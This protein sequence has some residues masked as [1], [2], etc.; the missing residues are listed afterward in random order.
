MNRPFYCFL[1][2][3]ILLATACGG[4]KKKSM[5]G[6]DEVNMDEFMEVYP[7]LTLPFTYGDS[8]FSEKENDSNLIAPQ[9]FHQFV[10]DS[11]TIAAFG[12]NARPRYYPVGS[13]D[14]GSGDFYLLSRGM[15][16]SQKILLITAYD[17]KKKFIAGLPVIKLSRGTDKT[18]SVTID[19]R[20]NINKNATQKLANGIEITGNDVFVLN[21]AAGKFM[22]IMTDSLGDGT[23]ELVNPIDTLP[24]KEKYSGDYGKG[25]TELIS[26][27]D[28]QREG[29]F[30]FFIHL[31]DRD[32]QCMGELKGEA[33]FNAPATAVYRQG[34]DPCVLRFVFE[35]NS[36]TL[37]EVEG[38]GSRL[39]ALQCSFNGTYPRKKEK[40]KEP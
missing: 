32:K 10:P 37:Q 6:G 7:K 13:I 20:L 5:T 36:I 17:K 29:R 1:L 9:V 40:K 35:K 16:P 19:P 3:L 34:G 4:K 8:T 28:G 39:G 12:A 15:T 25:K 11:L 2:M 27:R 22:L 38:C 33:V 18:V 14:A 23:T 26:I 21:K 31:E 24:R 30:R